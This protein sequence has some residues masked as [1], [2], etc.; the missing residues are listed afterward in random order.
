MLIR[1]I[2][3]ICLLLAVLCLAGCHKHVTP[4]YEQLGPPPA[5]DEPLPGLPPELLDG[6]PTPT[7]GEGPARVLSLPGKPPQIAEEYDIPVPI[8][9]QVKRWIDYFIGPGSKQFEL[10]LARSATYLPLI[11]QNLDTQGM[12]RDLAAVV[13]VESGYDPLAV[14][15]SQAVGLWQFLETTAEINGLR[16][17]LWIDERID[18][19]RSTEAAG[20]YMRYLYEQF[21][22]WHLAMAAYNGGEGTVRRGLSASGCVDFWTLARTNYISAQTRDY[23]PKILAAAV[24]M[25]DPAGYGFVDVPWQGPLVFETVSVPDSFSLKFLA[26]CAGTDADTLLALNP[27]LLTPFTPPNYPGYSMRVP[28]GTADNFYLRFRAVPDRKKLTY[29]MLRVRQDET[30]QSIAGHYQTHIEALSSVNGLRPGDEVQPGDL[31]IVPIPYDAA[32]REKFSDRLGHGGPAHIVTHVVR[33]GDTLFSITKRY[34]VSISELCSANRITPETPLSPGQTLIVVR[35]GSSPQT[36]IRPGDGAARAF[37]LRQS[38]NVIEHRIEPGQTFTAIARIYNTSVEALCEANDMRPHD[39]LYA[40]QTIKVRV[41]PGYQAHQAPQP[42]SEGD[43]KLVRVEVQTGDTL[44]S[45]ASYF[46]VT[47]GEIMLWN[48][49]K[50]GEQIKIGQILSIIVGP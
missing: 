15:R 37:N 28:A 31:L 22:D 47:V 14:S 49:L 50:P 10:W 23:V 35:S 16:V 46:D 21:G 29:R 5:D 48:N 17:D 27:A 26:A 12:P 13:Y 8:N 3:L 39:P 1:K 6:L 9:D 44:Y 2:T 24:I 20:N 45:L 41:P 4:E 7:P 43:S 36:S 42:A 11:W 32:R 33:K 18:P 30:L 40:G 38:N 34:N 25:H 19:R